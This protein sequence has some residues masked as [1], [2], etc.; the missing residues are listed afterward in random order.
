M[1]KE[2][3]LHIQVKLMTELICQTIKLAKRLRLIEQLRFGKWELP[4]INIG[5]D[6]DIKPYCLN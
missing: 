2:I 5:G 6:A 3:N 1:A 4:D